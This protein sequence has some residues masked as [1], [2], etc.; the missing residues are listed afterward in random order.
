M[1]SFYFAAC[2]P[3]LLL[4]GCG[5]YVDGYYYSPRPAM[6]AVPT[7]QPSEPP[8]VVALAS[9]IGIR[10][11]DSTLHIPLS[12]EI[13]LRLDNN[14]P[15]VVTF[16]PRMMELTTGDLVRFPPPVLFNTPPQ[17]V[18]EPEQSMVVTADFPFPD[19][20]PYDHFDL[21]TLQL[22][23]LE[24]IGTQNVTQ[25]ADFRRVELVYPY[26]YYG[27]DWGPYPYP[28]ISGAVIIR[29]R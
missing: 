28:Y 24:R 10:R 11:E 19:A 2:L 6:T 18:V 3:L 25:I 12:V 29:R 22:R 26:Y 4:V 5:P 17:L 27:P 20:Q 1:K 7:T 8:P 14:G 9:V 23:W 21:S 13:R 16:D 15:Q